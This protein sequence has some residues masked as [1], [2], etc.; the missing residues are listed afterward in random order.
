MHLRSS[1]WKLFN[2][3][4]YVVIL[5]LHFSKACSIYTVH[6]YYSIDG[7]YHSTG[8][9]TSDILSNRASQI[10]GISP[11]PLLSSPPP[12]HGIGLAGSCT[13]KRK[14]ALKIVILPRKKLHQ[15]NRAEILKIYAT[16]IVISNFTVVWFTL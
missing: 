1:Y 13:K 15:K 12:I 4:N 8:G 2:S 10:L 5:S 7:Q 14:R 6:I 16:R 3:R 11:F 9:L